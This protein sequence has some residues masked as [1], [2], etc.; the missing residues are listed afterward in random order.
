MLAVALWRVLRPHGATLI[1]VWRVDPRDFKETWGENRLLDHYL[2]EFKGFLLD[3]L[4]ATPVGA[5]ARRRYAKEL[6]A[7]LD[8]IQFFPVSARNRAT[9]RYSGGIVCNEKSVQKI[10]AALR[11][12]LGL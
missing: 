10:T 1:A 7:P 5:P 4:G 6:G 11:R 9:A 12:E 2:V 3:S 8:G